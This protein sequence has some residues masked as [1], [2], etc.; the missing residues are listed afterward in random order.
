MLC[1]NFIRKMVKK[2]LVNKLAIGTLIT[3]LTLYPVT[4]SN[5]KSEDYQETQNTQTTQQVQKT[6][7]QIAYE[8]LED[9]LS[10]DYEL[11]K[12][13]GYDD[14][15]IKKTSIDGKILN[16]TTYSLKYSDGAIDTLKMS[17]DTMPGKKSGSTIYKFYLDMFPSY[18]EIEVVDGEANVIS[19]RP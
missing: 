13:H 11:M 1:F 18:V 9:V 3:G 12:N 2:S 6:P 4:C 19:R 15:T 5:N 17:I 7:K 8:K 16:D 10:T 14:S